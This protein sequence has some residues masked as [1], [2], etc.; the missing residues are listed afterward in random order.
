MRGEW[1]A[2]EEVAGC[3]GPARG[4]ESAPAERELEL[5]V[6]GEVSAAGSQARSLSGVVR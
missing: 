5:P 3:L 2:G 1:L 6:L 4:W